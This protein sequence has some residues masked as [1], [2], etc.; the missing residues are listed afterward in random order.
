MFTRRPVKINE[1]NPDANEASQYAKN[2]IDAQRTKK[3]KLNL[4]DGFTMDD[5]KQLLS[6]CDDMEGHHI[7]WVD[8]NGNID[9]ALLPSNITPAGWA[10][11]MG[12]RIKFRY[13]TFVSGNEY[14]GFEAARDQKYVGELFED[15]M[16]DWKKDRKDYID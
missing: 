11:K 6:S 3:L 2:S 7:I 1:P 14:V 10:E 12:D 13:E 9:I 5:L 16:N 8:W 15:L 4:K